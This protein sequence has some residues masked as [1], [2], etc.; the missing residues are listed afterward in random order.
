MNKHDETVKKAYALLNLKRRIVGVQFIYEKEKYDSVRAI[1]PIRPMYYCQAVC[2]ACAGN[3][4]KLT[5]DSSGCR[6]SSRALGFVSPASEYYT[7]EAGLSLGLYENCEVAC[8]VARK[9]AI[10]HRPLYGISVMPV[11]MFES[12]PDVVLMVADTREAMRI[13]Q[14]YTCTYGLHDRFCMSGNQAICVECT[15]YPYINQCLNLSVLCAGTR[16][17]TDWKNDEVAVGIPYSKFEGLVKG[18]ENTV[19][20]IE[21]NHR[22]AEIEAALREEGL[23]HMNLEYGHTYFL[24]NDMSPKE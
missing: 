9:L 20:A 18:I 10:M 15:T 6:G 12:A 7:G 21:R 24:K 11:E 17:R 13:V 16:F 19:N 1:E 23:F 22:K 14:G 3:A 2:A 8:S 5:R 4:I